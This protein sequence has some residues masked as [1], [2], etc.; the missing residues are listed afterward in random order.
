MVNETQVTFAAFSTGRV[1]VDWRRWLPWSDGRFEAAGLSATHFAVKLIGRGGLKDSKAYSARSKGK[2]LA[3]MKRGNVSLLHLWA[4]QKGNTNFITGMRLETFFS[5]SDLGSL[6][7]LVVPA[8]LV[9]DTS[10]AMNGF[11]CQTA[12]FL[13]PEYGY[14][15]CARMDQGVGAYNIGLALGTMPEEII[16][17]C[18]LTRRKRWLSRCDATLR[19][20]YGVNVLSQDHM[21]IN[22]GSA[23]L[24]ERIAEKRWGTIVRISP[25]LWAWSLTGGRPEE[26]VYDNPC[27]RDIREAL[28]EHRLFCWQE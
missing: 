14:A 3:E 10:D 23:S 7:H 12:E 17:D 24:G 4:A 6:I 1:A 26:L 13:E 21:R 15:L 11:L 16:H 8:Q 22:L 2:L 19:N 28:K 25:R 9:T 18:N 20:V 5:T 27:I